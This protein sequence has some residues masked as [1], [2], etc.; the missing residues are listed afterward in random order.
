MN[1]DAEDVGTGLDQFIGEIQVVLQVVFCFA[2]IGDVSGIGDGGFDD[3]AGVA[4]GLHSQLQ[5]G[6]V[7]ECVEDPEDVHSVAHGQVAELDKE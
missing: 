3:S 1:L 5:V 2:G 7:V 4:H 6:H